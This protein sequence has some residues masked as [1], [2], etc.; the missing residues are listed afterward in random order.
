[1][2]RRS[3][4]VATM[5]AFADRLEDITSYGEIMNAKCHRALVTDWNGCICAPLMK[6]L[7]DDFDNIVAD[8]LRESKLLWCPF[9]KDEA[10]ESGPIKVT[11]AGGK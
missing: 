6:R 9:W 3:L 1:M 11:F 2:Q 7:R 8:A 4:L 10:M 5:G